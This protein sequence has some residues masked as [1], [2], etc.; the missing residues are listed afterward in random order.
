MRAS[1][2]AG[3]VRARRLLVLGSALAGAVAAA[4]I[5]VRRRRRIADEDG[6]A[7]LTGVPALEIAPAG[8]GAPAP[9]PASAA[10]ATPPTPP[11]PPTAST[12][13]PAP[14]VR[15]TRAELY[16]RAQAAGIKGRSNMTK[17]Q[18][19]QALRKNEA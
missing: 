1:L 18:L 3:L 16:R 15:P 19:E 13:A 10:G 12:A 11:T 5:A 17:A 4:V 14:T 8:E 2:T 9:P 6:A 7:S